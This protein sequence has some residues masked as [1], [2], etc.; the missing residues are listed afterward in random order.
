MKW[1]L[2]TFGI[3]LV[4]LLVFKVLDVLFLDKFLGGIF[5]L[6]EDFEDEN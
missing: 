4:A 5:N 1:D 2:Q 3:L 6:D